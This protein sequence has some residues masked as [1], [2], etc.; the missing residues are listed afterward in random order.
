[1][2]ASSRRAATGRAVAEVPWLDNSHRR[3]RTLF[4]INHF[5][6]SKKNTAEMIRVMNMLVDQY[7]DRRQIYLSW[8]AASW[9]VSKELNKHIEGHNRTGLG[10][11]VAVAPLPARAQFLNI[12]ESVF[13]GMARAII[14][15]S[16]YTA[17]RLAGFQ[18]SIRFESRTPRTLLAMAERG[19]GVA[20]IASGFRTD[21]TLRIVGLTYHGKPLRETLA[22][23]WD[24]RRPL[25]HYA[26]AFCEMLAE[27][28][29]KVFP[30]TQPSK[31][32]AAARTRKLSGRL[33]K[34]SE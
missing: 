28:M 22:V 32:K 17:C 7:R 9:H 8:D 34:G 20:V 21:H 30:I 24:K 12:I 23:F 1:M 4:Q 16:D 19:H 10:P 3:N 29:R 26:T 14:H 18:P 15:N 11:I 25:P 27:Y 6:C 5:Y 13:I 33:Q 2:A 31:F